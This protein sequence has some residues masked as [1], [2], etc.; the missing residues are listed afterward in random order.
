M[1]V[2]MIT[3]RVDMEHD[4][5]GFIHS[6]VD[7]L[8]RRVEHLDVITFRVGKTELGENVTLYS[9]YS[10]YQPVKFFRLNRFLLT[11][12]PKADVVFTHMYPW[13]PIVAAPYARA[14][15]KPLVMFNAHGHVDFKKKLAAKLVDKV[16]TSSE[17]GFNINTPKKVVIGQGIDT[18]RFKPCNNVRNNVFR[19]LNVGRVDRIKGYDILIDA[20]NQLVNVSGINKIHLTIIGP[21][22]D[23]SYFYF[24]NDKI[25]KYSIENYVTF[26]G[27]I[28]YK[29]LHEYYQNCDLFVNPSYASS[30]EK[31]V[32][33]AMA[34]EKPVL[35]SNIAYYNDV[36]DD[37][38]REK[39]FF[40]PG[41]KEELVK[42]IEY[43]MENDEKE[44]R[45]KLR[46]IVVENHSIENFVKSLV[47]IFESVKR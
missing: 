34:C 6:W 24:L 19:I 23:R 38:L 43:F 47:L 40:A 5:F 35:T 17:R 10:K 33:E 20:I 39:C 32:L 45:K 26:E 22:Y 9:A 42:K 14:F 1:R 7:E 41:N 15:G 8:S 13:L 31:T 44:L 37:E 21:I 3:P 29:R 30:L 36:F 18:K 25:L 4:I 11:L 2:L 12:T 28:P 27:Q 16:V 46:K